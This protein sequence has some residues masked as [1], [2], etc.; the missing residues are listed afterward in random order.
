MVSGIFSLIMGS[1]RELRGQEA[2]KHWQESD[3]AFMG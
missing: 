1:M 3:H 2:S